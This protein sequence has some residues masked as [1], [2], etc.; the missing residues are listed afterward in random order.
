MGE[1]YEAT[2]VTTS[3]PAA[4]KLLRR[5][6][7]ADPTQVARFVREAKAGGTLASPHIARVLEASAGDDALPYI[8][9]ERL[10]GTSL[11]DLLRRDGA[12]PPAQTVEMIGQIGAGID[13]AA[14][15]GIVH[16][17]LKPQNLFRCDLG[18]GASLW[19]ILDF[20]IAT[21]SDD[22]GTLTHGG[23]VGTPSYMAPEQAKGERVDHRADLFALAAVAYRCL[24]GRN[25]FTG[26][27]TPTLLYA[28]VHRQ[29][30]RPTALA[31]LAPDVDRW[32]AIA[33]A[34]DR[35]HR[36]DRG[37]ALYDALAAALRGRLEPHLRKRADALIK[38]H[39]WESA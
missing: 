36:F 5:E 31:D 7:L 26:P 24:T 29:P 18:A 33:L 35:D 16:R 10:H 1:V 25:P 32:V 3:A 4:V 37:S 13:A 22:T 38:T 21:L 34:K 27:D 19:K 17:D 15:A 2:G 11:A 9:M 20:G 30:V 28:V 6:L 12:L 23:I 39:P 8:A 14:G